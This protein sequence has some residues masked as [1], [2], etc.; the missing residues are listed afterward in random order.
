MSPVRTGSCLC[1]ISS[2]GLRFA[3][4]ADVLSPFS[5][6][7]VPHERTKFE[8]PPMFW[9]VYYSLSRNIAVGAL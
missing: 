3:L 7:A 1:Q 5:F 9:F 6:L 8:D 4:L 2:G